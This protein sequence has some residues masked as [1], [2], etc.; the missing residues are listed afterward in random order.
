[1]CAALV[2]AVVAWRYI[3]LELFTPLTALALILLK[4]GDAVIVIPFTPRRARLCG[5]LPALV[6][7]ERQKEGEPR[8][9]HK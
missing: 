1:M 6:P 2:A 7:S 4:S 5:R 9:A 8:H 3:C